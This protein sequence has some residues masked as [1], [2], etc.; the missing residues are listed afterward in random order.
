MKR[1]GKGEERK[2]WHEV[3]KERG[4]ERKEGWELGTF[5]GG[6]TA[7]YSSVSGTDGERR[8]ICV[9]EKTDRIL[10]QIK[11]HTHTH[12]SMSISICVFIEPT[13]TLA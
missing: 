10:G 7:D 12:I 8:E 13:Q 11:T 1:E 2:N 9:M 3:G 5:S 4:M 6:F